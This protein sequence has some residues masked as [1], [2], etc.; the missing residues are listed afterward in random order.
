LGRASGIAFAITLGI[1]R[2]QRGITLI[3][4]VIVMAII[5]VL[6]TISLTLYH[7]VQSRSRVAKAQADT[8]TMASAVGAYHAHMG[9][10][11]AALA[12]LSIAQTNDT[13]QVAGPFMAG[14]PTPPAG[15][16]YG[17]ATGG[18]SGY[19]ITASGDST[20]ITRP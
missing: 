2:N 6:G 13:G 15:W 20:T 18:P 5:L 16:T 14:D 1:V 17:Y 12:E 11:P 8:Q 4:L 9:Q 19:T 7:N 3:E 10:V